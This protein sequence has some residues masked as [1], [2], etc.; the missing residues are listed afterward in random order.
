ML[1]FKWGMPALSALR[2]QKQGLAVLPKLVW[3]IQALRARTA[4]VCYHGKILFMSLMYEDIILLRT[5]CFH[6]FFC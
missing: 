3:N 1:I 4:G 5:A 2:R 6:F